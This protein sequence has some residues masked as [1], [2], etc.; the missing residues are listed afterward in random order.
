MQLFLLSFM[1]L[2]LAVTFVS[3]A[4]AN[5]PMWISDRIDGESVKIP[6]VMQTPPAPNELKVFWWN[7]REG[8]AWGRQMQSTAIQHGNRNAENPLEV[9]LK[10][11]AAS[12]TR[13]DVIVLGE[14]VE[15]SLT[16][17]T[18]TAL[19]RAYPYQ[20]YFAYNPLRDMGLQVYSRYAIDAKVERLDW[21]PFPSTPQEQ[22]SFKNA[23][24]E[25]LNPEADKYY[26]RPFVDLKIKKSG[27]VWHIVPAHI[28][29][30]WLSLAA[31]LGTQQA[32]LVLLF[33]NE[34]PHYYQVRRLMK[35]K[36]EPLLAQ[37]QRDHSSVVVVGDFNL[38]DSLYGI[39]P[40]AYRVCLKNLSEVR[41]S[42]FTF[43]AVTA[44]NADFHRMAI[45]HAF[46]NHFTQEV[47]SARPVLTGSDHYP[48]EVIFRASP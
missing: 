9:N 21:T 36:I 12:A 15:D 43:P 40:R 38:P 8:G 35:E 48:L 41:Q 30:N 42:E 6:T 44:D 5:A 37:S 13:P 39:T 46:Y 2:C 27:F 34:N 31:Q 26:D 14:Y 20:E 4:S 45:D 29:N 23:W 16:D 33:G 28:L 11:L 7:I 1:R 22:A 32:G 19:S 18:E 24:K 3:S 47:Q 25:K 10:T 17:E